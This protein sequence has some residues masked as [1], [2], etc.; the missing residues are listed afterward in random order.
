MVLKAPFMSKSGGVSSEHPLASIAGSQV[1]REGGNAVDASVSVSLALAV[2]QPHLGS[3][4]GDFF[5]LIYESSS[6]KVYCINSSGW[7]PKELNLQ[8]L[9]D[10]GL[11]EIPVASPHAVVVPGMIS[12]LQKIHERFGTLKFSKLAEYSI[13]LA[14]EGFPASHRFS[15]AINRSRGKLVSEYARNLFFKGGNPPAAGELILQKQLANTLRSVAFDPRSF[16]E[17]WIAESLCKFL[18]SK[19]GVFDIDDFVD[20]EGEWVEPLKSTYRGFEVYE[21]PPNSQGATSLIIL[22]ILENFDLPILDPLEARRIHLFA[23]AAKRAYIDKNR[24]LADP[25]FVDIPLDEILSKSHG[26]KLAETIREDSVLGHSSLKPGDTTNFVVIDKSG[27]IVS[28]IQSLFHGFGSGLI[29]P[30]TGILLNSRASY[31]NLSGP[32]KVEPRKRPLHTLSSMIAISEDNEIL[33]I[34]TSGGD[35]RPQQH[36]LLLTNI[37]D[38]GLDLQNAVELPR[39]L[40]NGG[41]EIIMEEGFHGLDELRRIGHRIIVREYPNGMGVAHCGIRRGEVT[42]L[43]ADVRG[44]G[45]PS[46]PLL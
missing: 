41:A 37:V 7:S 6:G 23:E 29:D 19:G 25:R 18:N 33:A 3:I 22:N 44:D 43:S 27:N 12:G 31:F 10:L 5:A 24:Y 34:G 4:G 28:A 20:F 36:A 8:L 11:K 46:G 32:N 14:E 26:K 2:T 39:F 35:Y 21:V 16:Y 30:E 15:E 40:W 13:K 1:L 42:M 38:H 45:L 9:E 17:G